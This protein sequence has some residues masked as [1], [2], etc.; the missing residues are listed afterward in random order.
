MMNGLI[1]CLTGCS[2]VFG[3]GLIELGMTYSMEQAVLVN[4]MI[5]L[6]RRIAEGVA[7]DTETLSYEDIVQQGPGGNF[8]PL[9]RTMS[10][11]ASQTNPEFSDRNMIDEWV[12][13]GKPEAIDQAHTRVMDILANHQVNLIEKDALD[14][15]DGIVKAADKRLQCNQ[16]HLR[17]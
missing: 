17:E 6:I 9:P 5:P 3:V 1:P 7:V 2:N 13:A 12:K 16:N 4:D 10:G 14:E 15:I 8:I 11:M